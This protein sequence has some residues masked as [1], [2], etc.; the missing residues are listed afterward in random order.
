[1][2]R[3]V[4]QWA[5]LSV[6]PRAP[7][8]SARNWQ[9]PASSV[10]VEAVLDNLAVHKGERIR[11]LIEVRR[12]EL[13][14]LPAYSPDLTPI[15]EAFSKLKAGL[16]RLGARTRDA[17]LEAIGQVVATITAQD[18]HGWFT[19]AGCVPVLLLRSE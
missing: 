12:C 11:T 7:G 1:M 2:I 3:R 13:W 18:A 16:R 4:G 17:Y 15:G 8:Q 10:Y 19:D 5:R 9:R 6:G 14:F